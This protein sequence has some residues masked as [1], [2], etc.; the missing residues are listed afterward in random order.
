ME[1][2]D[3]WGQVILQFQKKTER[4]PLEETTAKYDFWRKANI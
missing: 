1:S 2:L 4:V 3:H